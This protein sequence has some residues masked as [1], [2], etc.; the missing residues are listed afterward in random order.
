[1]DNFRFPILLVGPKQTHPV[2][3]HLAR[4]SSRAG[5]L[6]GGSFGAL[7]LS[8]SSGLLTRRVISMRLLSM[9]RR[10]LSF[11]VA[12]G[13]LGWVACLLDQRAALL[14]PDVSQV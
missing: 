12:I 7:A 13:A 1:M 9:S 10:M 11:A 3:S 14:R 2:T 6:D 5:S 4:P 8:D